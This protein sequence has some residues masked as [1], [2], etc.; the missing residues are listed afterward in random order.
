MP[1]RLDLPNQHFGLSAVNARLA[2]R[3]PELARDLTGT[4]PTTASR[5]ELRFRGKGSLAVCV[6]G[7]RR[8]SWC[9]HEA[10]CGGD[11]VGLVA[12]L[13]NVPMREALAW[14][15]AWLGHA[16]APGGRRTSARPVAPPEAR[17]APADEAGKAWS[18]DLARRLWREGQA[19][20][21]TLVETY[22]TARGLLLPH[23]AP[24]RFHP[25]AWRNSANGPRGPAM[26]ALMTSPEANEPV[27]TH[28]TYL[29]PDG[30]GKASGPSSK[31][32]LGSVGVVRLVPDDDVTMGLGLAE[33]IETALATMQR[34]G[35]RPIWAATCA[36]SVARFPVLPGIE[37]LKLFADADAVGLTAAR[38]SAHRWADAG[39]EGWIS[40]PPA[41]DWDEATLR[42]GA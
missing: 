13:R 34:T 37:C 22:L 16:P 7:P 15:L 24:L 39:R 25:A 41:G 17:H 11:P 40:H 18:L 36:G 31:V 5:G 35:W 27:G 19:P 21:A 33:G 42:G 10:G 3:M 20:A 6:A 32:M 30:R 14:A 2:E 9:D 28:I 38:A 8:G 4:A 12:H 29:A 23:D 1:A 26:L